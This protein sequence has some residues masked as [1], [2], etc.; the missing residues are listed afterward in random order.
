MLPTVSVKVNQTWATRMWD[1]LLERGWVHGFVF[2]NKKGEQAKFLTY[3][4]SFFEH[5]NHVLAR[6]PDLFP[7]NVNVEDDYG[8][9]CSRRRGLATEAANQGVLS[10][11]IEMIYRWRQNIFK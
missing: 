1:S 6:L 11:K 4:P 2:A 9:S 5:L 8:V 10:G 7:P 3:E